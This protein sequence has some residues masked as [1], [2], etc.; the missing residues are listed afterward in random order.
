MSEDM[1]NPVGLANWNDPSPVL[2]E[3]STAG[4]K[5]N[6]HSREHCTGQILVGPG[7][8]RIVHLESHLELC[9]CLTLMGRES[10]ADLREQ[11]GFGWEDEQGTM[12]RHWFDFLV[13][14]VDGSRLAYSVK[15]Q[16]RVTER[17]LHEM[18]RIAEQA[19]ESGFVDDVRLLTDEN[20]DRIDLFNAKLFFAY[21]RPEPAADRLAHEIHDAMSGLC[22]LGELV[23]YFDEPGDGFRAFVRR[24]QSGHLKLARH[25]QISLNS[26]V[27]KAKKVT[28]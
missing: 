13:T 2:P 24:I 20:L 8:G 21:R 26:N 10:T 6:R 4:R 3:P 15:P 9:W 16:V 11:V 19:R 7:G 27:F 5:I 28:Q 12:R 14:E 17:F 18:S 23:A 25:E 22:K 1:M